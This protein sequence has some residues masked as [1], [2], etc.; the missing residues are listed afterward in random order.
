MFGSHKV[1]HSAQTSQFMFTQS[2][3]PQILI[4]NIKI[5]IMHDNHLGTE[6]VIHSFLDYKESLLKK[7][8]MKDHKGLK[9]TT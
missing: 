2:C 4:T 8:N 9:K 1:P 7:S 5:E 3:W 6:M